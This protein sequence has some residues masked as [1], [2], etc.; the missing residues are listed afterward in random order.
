[1]KTNYRINISGSGTI[2]QIQDAL[3]NLAD[4]SSDS[5]FLY[6]GQSSWEWEDSTLYTEISEVN[7]EDSFTF[8]ED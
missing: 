8:N 3:R 7:N 4:I 5:D 6:D 1:M 2:D